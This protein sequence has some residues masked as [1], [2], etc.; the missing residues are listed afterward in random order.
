MILSFDEGR[1]H[2]V[3]YEDTDSYRIMNL[4]MRDRERL[5]YNLLAEKENPD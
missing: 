3:P 2:P 5:L 4:F 1:V